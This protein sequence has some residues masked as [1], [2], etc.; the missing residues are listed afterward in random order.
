MTV[1][2]PGSVY[3]LMSAIWSLLGSD[4]RLIT[5]LAL[6]CSLS[7]AHK[8]TQRHADARL[9]THTC[10]Y[11]WALVLSIYAQ[12]QTYCPHT[13][14]S[15]V[16]CYYTILQVM[17]QSICPQSVSKWERDEER[18]VAA[19]LL[20]YWGSGNFSASLFYSWFFPSFVVCSIF[21]HWSIPNMISLFV[22]CQTFS[23][24]EICYTQ[25]C[26]GLIVILNRV[27]HSFA[28]TKKKRIC[29]KV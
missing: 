20:H 9:M 25:S 21:L 24:L 7:R 3:V 13:Y 8:H 10:T 28:I 22:W 5:T 14:A 12:L 2:S 16:S 1:G 6:W 19:L 26:F 29:S 27:S 18:G 17:N 15:C 4:C 11:T 23:L